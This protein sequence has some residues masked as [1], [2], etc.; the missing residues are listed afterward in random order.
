MISSTIVPK[1]KEVSFR[2]D[3]KELSVA[4]RVELHSEQIIARE[5]SRSDLHSE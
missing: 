5:E 2:R 1:S 4:S 3:S